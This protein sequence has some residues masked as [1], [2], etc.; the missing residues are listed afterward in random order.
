MPSLLILVLLL[1]AAW[2][3]G[4]LSRTAVAGAAVERALSGWGFPAS[5]FVAAV[6][7]T[8]YV[9]GGL[10]PIAVY[11]DEAAYLLQAELL[12]RFR[13]TLPSPVVTR[14]FEQAAVLVTP[15]L[16]PK[17]GPG[18]ALAL[19]PGIWLGM[20]ALM[21]LLLT[22][23]A[24]ALV[25]LLSRRVAGGAVALLTLVLWL[26][27]SGNL[28]WRPTYFS[29]TSSSVAWLGTWWCLLEWRATR[30]RGWLLAV[31]ALTGWGAVTRPLT[32][33]AFAVPLGVV[34]VRDVVRARAWRD[35]AYAVAM[36]TLCLLV[37]PL[38][39]WKV[40]GHPL[41]SPLA[42]YTRQYLPSDVTGFGLHVGRAERPLPADIAR[43][44]EDFD[45]LHAEHSLAAL[46]RT[47]GERAG[48]VF[49]M[50][51]GGWRAALAPVVLVAVL[52]PLPEL[53]FAMA[54]ALLVLVAYLAYAHVP[55]W[56]VYYLELIPVM[57]FAAAIGLDRAMRWV[58]QRVR[59]TPLPAEAGAL[60]AALVLVISLWPS[61]REVDAY[62][63]RIEHLTAYQREYFDAM[64]AIPEAKALVFVKYG[65][66]HKPHY[67]LIR[68]VADPAR[69]HVVTAYDLG[70]AANDS[71]RAAFPDR[72]VYLLD[73]SA[74]TLQKIVFAP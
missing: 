62:R 40:T 48:W 67:S 63:R 21:P 53:L 6:A 74:R 61:A 54:T 29:E 59:P 69:A 19:L 64:R 12:A 1:G 47:F 8:W 68:N 23:A 51:F 46:P 16:A 25:V 72:T 50:Q 73:T 36:G 28:V 14:A 38:Q 11:H 31:A 58:A 5:A 56:T 37:I 2:L 7:I 52:S 20:P 45:K 35:L 3:V 24:A 30:T 39:A 15:V 17:M 60:A 33:L 13:W 65:K 34:V 10:N 32:F 66:G 43:V 18:H 57:S 41:Q 71:V 49:N 55:Q 27:A 4:R 22:G 42:L 70:P 44:Y 26:T 9:W